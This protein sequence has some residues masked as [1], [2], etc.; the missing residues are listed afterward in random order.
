MT[1]KE[2]A[3]PLSPS[4]NIDVGKPN[5]QNNVNAAED[6]M[7]STSKSS[8]IPVRSQC[9]SLTNFFNVHKLFTCYLID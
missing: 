2:S 5:H 6:L 1:E 7:N 8:V 4:V 9:K 3:H